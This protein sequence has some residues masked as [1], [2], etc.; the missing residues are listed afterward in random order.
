MKTRLEK[1]EVC[2]C[3]GNIINDGNPA[4]TDFNLKQIRKNK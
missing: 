4:E 2:E 1:F 3:C